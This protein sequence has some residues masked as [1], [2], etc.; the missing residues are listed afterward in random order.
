MWL[1][2]RK[3]SDT[4]GGCRYMLAGNRM[5][6]PDL[7]IPGLSY[8]PDARDSNRDYN[9]EPCCRPNR[10]VNTTDDDWPSDAEVD[11]RP[12]PA[13]V[14][15]PVHDTTPVRIPSPVHI[16]MQVPRPSYTK[17][18]MSSS[19]PSSMSSEVPSSSPS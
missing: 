10:D 12:S 14:P 5:T 4:H 19:V 13:H 6:N 9:R 3:W 2:L 15:N 1:W 7:M 16:P 8:I 11:I 17:D 18:P